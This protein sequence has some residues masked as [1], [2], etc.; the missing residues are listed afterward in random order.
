MYSHVDATILLIPNERTLQNSSSKDLGP[1]QKTGKCCSWL[2]R[3]GPRSGQKLL[4]ICK[5]GLVNSA[6]SGGTTT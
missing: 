5:I 3:T 2:K 6:E 1:R 4:S